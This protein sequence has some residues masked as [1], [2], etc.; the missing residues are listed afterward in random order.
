MKI[1][2]AEKTPQLP[3]QAVDKAE[4]KQVPGGFE[5]VLQQTMQKTGQSRDSAGAS[6]RS[7]AGPQAPLAANSVPEN[8]AETMADKLLDTLEAYQ[9]MLGDPDVTLK[10]IQPA[11]EQMQT[12]A[13]GTRELIAGLQEAHPLKTILQDTVDSIDREITRFNAGYYVT[14]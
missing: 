2:P 9:K 4:K 8:A 5:A 11:V 3:R 13:A 1:G 7:M 6:I 10:R 12:Q 14:D